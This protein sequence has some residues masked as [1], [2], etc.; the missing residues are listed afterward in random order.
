MGKDDFGGE[1]GHAPTYALSVIPAQAGIQLRRDVMDP[2][3][4][5]DDSGGRVTRCAQ[6]I[7]IG[8]RGWKQYFAPASG[9]GQVGR[10]PLAQLLVTPA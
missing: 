10:Q 1:S 3:L 5:G 8:M 9:A 2:R 4:R 7:A 6:L